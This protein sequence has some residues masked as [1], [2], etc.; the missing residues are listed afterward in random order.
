M[1]QFE[2][3]SPLVASL[4]AM[5]LLP[6]TCARPAWMGFVPFQRRE[7]QGPWPQATAAMVHVVKASQLSVASMAF[8]V[9]PV[10]RHRGGAGTHTGHADT[11]RLPVPRL[12]RAPDRGRYWAH[13]RSRTSRSPAPA[14]HILATTLTWHSSGSE[15]R[16]R[17]HGNRRGTSTN[18]HRPRVASRRPAVR[19]H[20]FPFLI[21]F[22]YPGY[23]RP[24]W[25]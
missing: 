2:P 4:E 1:E 12:A 17:S 3:S 10:K 9:L 15:G 23:R 18:V 22:A 24:L 16:E 11:Q 20:P 14:P 7:R 5:Q 6:P 19:P 8:G 25:K 13:A 21:D